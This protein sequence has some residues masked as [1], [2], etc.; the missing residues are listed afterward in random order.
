MFRVKFTSMP[1]SRLSLVV[2]HLAGAICTFGAAISVNGTCHVGN[3]A[4]PD[5]AAAGTAPSTP[6]DFVVTLPNT[7]RYHI[8]GSVEA[9][10]SG[11]SVDLQAPFTVTYL[12]NAAGKDSREDVL[13]IDLLQNCEY[14]PHAGRFF[15][16]TRGGFEGPIAPASAVLG[17]LFV[18]GQALPVQGPFPVPAASRSFWVDSGPLPITGLGNPL[19]LDLRR[20]ITFAAGSGV[21]SKVSNAANLRPQQR[22]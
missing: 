16:V 7:D 19:L 22:K 10:A 14:T 1:R 11:N 5:V 21:G 9:S 4:S 12:G 20:T 17:Q 3:C 18:G 8:S 15:E 13:T 2:L 6:F